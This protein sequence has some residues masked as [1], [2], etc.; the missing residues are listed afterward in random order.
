MTTPVPGTRLLN[1]SR[2]HTPSNRPVPPRALRPSG[3][4]LPLSARPGVPLS[5]CPPVSG[6]PPIRGRPCSLEEAIPAMSLPDPVDLHWLESPPP[7]PAPTRWGLPWRR[8]SITSEPRFHLVR[9][10]EHT[11]ELQSRGHLVCR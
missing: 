7:S 6:C 1:A 8:G 9:S 5:L 11:S 2:G 4:L 10:E 3:C